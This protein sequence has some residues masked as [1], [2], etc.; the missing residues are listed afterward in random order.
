M[1]EPCWDY[2]P[3]LCR[4]FDKKQELVMHVTQLNRADSGLQGP[5]SCR[6]LA[7]TLPRVPGAGS[8]TIVHRIN[9]VKIFP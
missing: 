4:E 3:P 1:L 5:E 9:G 7:N 8:R 2:S 6:P